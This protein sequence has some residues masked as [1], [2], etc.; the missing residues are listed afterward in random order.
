MNLILLYGNIL[1]MTES[2][3]VDACIIGSGAGGAVV[4]KEL[5]EKGLSV[6]VLEAG[7]RFIAHKDF[8]VAT[9]RDWERIGYKHGQKFKLPKIDKITASHNNLSRPTV[10]YGVGGG[11]LRYLAHL[12]RF[13]PDDFRI[14]SLDGVGADWPIT[15]KDLVP[16]YRKVEWELGVSGKSG[17]P[18]F[19]MVDEYPNPPFALSYATKN[20]KKSFDKLGIKI[21]YRP[22][23]RPTRPFDGRPACIYC[24][25]CTFGCMINAKSSTLVTYIPKA[26]ATGNAEICAECAV[27][28]IKVDDKGRAS[29]VI[30]F[31]KNDKEHELKAKVIIMSAGAVQSP[32]IL[33]NSKSSLF[34]DGLANSSGMVG[35]NFMQHI[36][37]SSSAVFHK[38]LDSFRGY[39]DAVSYDFAKTDNKNSFARGYYIALKNSTTGPARPAISIKGWGHYHKEYMRNSFGYTAGLSTGGE[40]LPDMRNSVLLDQDTVDYYGMPVPRITLELRENEKLM[41]KHMEMK[42]REI[43][44]A[45]RVKEILRMETSRPGGGSHNMGTCRMGENTETS[46]VN[47]FCQSHDVPNL[48]IVDASCFVTSGSSNPSLTIMAIAK[49]SAEYIIEEGKKGNL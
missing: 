7:K 24:G 20:F 26:E 28:Q 40:M 43:Y 18:W 10:V 48:F 6:V 14:Y 22:G 41:L 49:R 3:R 30:Y 16:Y 13:L 23:G 37:I 12:V 45:A 11:T 2:D 39:G 35:R 9:L 38:R 17:D 8:T 46:I 15:Y 31:D 34:P 29:S 27:T 21:W 44:S 19:P 1:S 5:S 36:S 32:R 25:Q 33:L 42:L 47:S 4:A